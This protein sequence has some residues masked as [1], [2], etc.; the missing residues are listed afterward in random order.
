M[1]IIRFFLSQHSLK[2][3]FLAS[4]RKIER[5]TNEKQKKIMGYKVD[6]VDKD[7]IKEKS[8]RDFFINII[9]ILQ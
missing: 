3:G 2:S 5:M 1:R 9:I 7:K 6:K 8:L 4:I